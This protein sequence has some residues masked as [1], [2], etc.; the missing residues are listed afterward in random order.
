MTLGTKLLSAISG[1]LLAL[2]ALPKPASAQSVV[3]ISEILSSTS[4]SEIDT[5]SATEIDYQTSLY[6]GAYVEG[7][8]YQNGTLIADGSASDPSDAYG[9][10]SQPLQVPDVY[11]LES[12]H[13]LVATYVYEYYD[14]TT[15][16]SN[17]DYYL[18][19]TGDSTD[20]SG[21]SFAPGGGPA[22]Y[23][24]Q[25]LYLGTTA[26]AMSSA[27]PT[28]TSISPTA[29]TVGTSGTITVYGDNLVDVFTGQASA[30]ITGSGVT[31][32]VNSASASQV[33][34][35]YSIS[36]NASTGSQNL[37]LSTRFG[38]SNPAAFNVGDPSP[39]INSISP[40]TWQAGTAIQVTITGQHFGTNP[41]L[42]VTGPGV[43][44]SI[45]S[46]SDTQIVANV[47]IAISS[48]GG[49]ATVE[50]Q[51]N[52]YGGNGFLGTN[53]GQSSQTTNSAN[54]QPV[55]PAPQI[56]FNGANVSGTTQNVVVGQQIA[57]SIAAPPSGLS[58]QSGTWSGVS[59]TVAAGVSAPGQPS[60]NGW[61][62]GQQPCGLAPAK[63]AFT[64]YMDQRR[65]LGTGHVHRYIHV[66]T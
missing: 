26:V 45:V 29:G 7:Y 49:T 27:G 28:I 63:D 41:S 25:Y 33:T 62:P 36:T 48:P 65:N 64:F 56:L 21:S 3:G 44:A 30:S 47:T 39:V 15:Y 22:Y 17:P 40:D 51:S 1:L 53:P 6:Y 31:L 35:N 24:T 16:W 38:T 4:S 52:G 50:V 20:P 12:D 32:S 18:I 58:I 54:V 34:L 10:M 43:T 60:C 23:D 37:T 13:Y 61:T 2:V 57:L 19:D 66:D 14:G 46:A 8:L 11:Q 5:Y 42:T 59:A 9:Y 55:N